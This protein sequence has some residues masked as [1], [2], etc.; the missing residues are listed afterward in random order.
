MPG[1][2]R[3]WLRPL[4]FRGTTATIAAAVSVGCQSGGWG[5]LFDR[6]N[7]IH[8]RAAV[9]AICVRNGD[10][11]KAVFCEQFCHNPRESGNVGSCQSTFY[12]ASL[13]QATDGF[14]ENSL[15]FRS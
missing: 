2:F 14:L 9:S 13:R 15:F 11:D 10:A 12:Q 7:C 5:H 8:Q 3:F 4:I 6:E 1:Y